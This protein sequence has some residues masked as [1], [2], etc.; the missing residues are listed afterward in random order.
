[1]KYTTLGC[2]AVSADN[3]REAAEIFANRMARKTYGKSGYC[4]TCNLESW[5]QDRSR[6]D[7]NAFIGYTPSGQHNT[8]LT[9]GNNIRFTVRLA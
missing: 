7:Y 9:V 3:M 8:G 5:S 1:M 2:R 6:G 4:R